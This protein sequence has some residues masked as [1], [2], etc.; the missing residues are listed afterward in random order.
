MSWILDILSKFFF[1][2]LIIAAEI[3]TMKT[4]EKI[5]VGFTK[6]EPFVSIDQIGT[7]KGLDEFIMN[8]FARKF[9]LSLEYVEKNIS[10]NE[11]S[12]NKET[13]EEYIKQKDV[14]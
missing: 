10:L 4:T 5:F 2:E 7:Q 11:I 12:N 13:F 14:E 9:N 6:R 3:A 8:N 1:F